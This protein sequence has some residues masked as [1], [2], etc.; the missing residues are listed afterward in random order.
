MLVLVFLG[1]IFLRSRTVSV[2]YRKVLFGNMA[3]TLSEL[4]E[5]PGHA[6]KGAG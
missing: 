6:L 4:Y 2:I 5:S 3:K 1:N